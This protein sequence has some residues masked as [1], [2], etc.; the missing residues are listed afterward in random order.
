VRFFLAR[1]APEVSRMSTPTIAMEERASLRLGPSLIIGQA[2]YVLMQA[3]IPWFAA[4]QTPIGELGMLSLA[5]SIVWPLAMLTQM[6][7]NGVYLLRGDGGLLPV[8]LR[9]R[10]LGSALLV[11]GAVAVAMLT[12][13]GRL[14]IE[15]ALLL[16]LIKC[17][18]GLS[19]TALM[20]FHRRFQPER[21]A[22][23]MTV[24]CG[25]FVAAYTVCLTLSG[26]L[27]LSMLLALAAMTIWVV[28]IDLRGTLSFQ[29]LRPDHLDRQVVPGILGAGLMLSTALAI[30]SVS[31]MV[32]RWAAMRE[33]DL[34]TMGA[35]VL[36]ATVASVVA[37]LVSTCQQLSLPG[38]R[39]HF[40]R[41]GIEACN[42]SLSPTNRALHIAFAGLILAWAGAYLIAST[43]GVHLPLLGQGS[44]MLR[45]TFALA[46]CYLVS[47][48]LSV[49]HFK[50]TMLLVIAQQNRSIVAIAVVQAMAA[51]AVSFALYPVVGWLAI[52]LA[53]LARGCAT[54]MAVSY[55]ARRY[56]RV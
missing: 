5:Q 20:E 46:G 55:L 44:P 12:G 48:W 13:S 30:S 34:T 15:L 37:V 39:H 49:F 1:L 21:A 45:V 50:Q 40:A 42:A 53:E 4:T 8:F 3:Y 31:L 10:V 47:G 36:A 11:V 24:R 43:F 28:V 14:L 18:E 38:G 6:Q 52:A 32:G 25:I 56:V 27:V 41:A 19:D 54:W 17:A 2:A 7:L 51:A 16:A 22:R 33:G 23:T 26:N 29:F 9:L 35:A